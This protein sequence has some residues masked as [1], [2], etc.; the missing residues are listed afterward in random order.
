[1]EENIE[2]LERLADQYVS[3]M[4]EDRALET[5]ARLS[6]KSERAR[7]ILQ[8]LTQK[9][10]QTVQKREVIERTQSIEPT[11]IR[12]PSRKT[13][14]HPKDNYLEICRELAL[15]PDEVQCDEQY[16][17]IIKARWTNSKAEINGKRIVIPK[18]FFNNN[19]LQEGATVLFKV[20][21]VKDDK[22]IAKPI[23]TVPGRIIRAK[24]FTTETSLRIS[25][26]GEDKRVIVPKEHLSTLLL[27]RGLWK[28]QVLREND[29]GIIAKPVEK[30]TKTMQEEQMLSKLFDEGKLS[31]SSF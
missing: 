5:L 28:L 19:I 25:P 6:V 13:Y 27:N 17:P 3:R 10:A 1:M 15:N 22:V 31:L 16:Y 29:K 21:K 7:K 20:F 2:I 9:K 11:I 12:K 30:I 26:M 14:N 24:V 23:K 18:I 8:I 4:G